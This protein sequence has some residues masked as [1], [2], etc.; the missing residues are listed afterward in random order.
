MLFYGWNVILATKV[1]LGVSDYLANV[2]L[3]GRGF[4]WW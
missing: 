1:C 3:S 2:G 4:N